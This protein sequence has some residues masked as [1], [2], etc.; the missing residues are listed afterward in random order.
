MNNEWQYHVVKGIS[1]LVCR[2]PY[3]LIL[4][5]GAGL[6]PLYGVIAKKQ[7][8]RG[9]KN[10]KIGMNMNDKQAEA[11]IEKLFKNLGRSV[12]EILYMPN[13]T[14]KFIDEH[15]EMRGVEYLDNAIKE[16][17]GVIVLTGHVGNWEWMGAALAAHGYPSTTI[18]K[19][20]PNA[21]LRA[22]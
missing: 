7:K 13:L 18:V 1:W 6:G 22:L 3:K 17:K 8:L 19:K 2:L 21:Q 16:D 20:Q 15:I 14:K 5:I 12:M 10:I 9:I 4:L 11:L